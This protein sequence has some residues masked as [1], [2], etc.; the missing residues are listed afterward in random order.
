MHLGFALLIYAFMLWTALGCPGYAARLRLRGACAVSAGSRSASLAITIIW[1]AFTA[2]LHAGEAYN[3]WPLMEGEFFPSAALTILPKWPQVRSKIL[4]FV[5]F[6]HR[7]LGPTTA[8]LILAWVYRLWRTN[9]DED[10]RRWALA[11]GAMAILQVALGLTA[12]L[13]THA[14]IIVAVT[15]IRQARSRCLTLLLINL[16]RLTPRA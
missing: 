6:I 7:W 5:Q 15:C 3:T 2:G 8:L 9:A 1:G 14:E 4:R 16:R 11:L 13:L 12:L 10:G